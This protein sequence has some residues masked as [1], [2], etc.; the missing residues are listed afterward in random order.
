MKVAGVCLDETSLGD[1]ESLKVELS[2]CAK[3]AKIAKLFGHELEILHLGA[4]IY[5]D[6][7]LFEAFS[8]E[9]ST[10]LDDH[11]FANYR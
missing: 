5:E 8:A 4:I 9:L 6:L 10:L 7:Q 1:V 3:V 11:A 2:K